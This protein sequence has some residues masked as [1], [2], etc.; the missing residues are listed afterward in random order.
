MVRVVKVHYE[1]QECFQ[2][3][4]MMTL[5][6]STA[7]EQARIADVEPRFLVNSGILEDTALLIIVRSGAMRFI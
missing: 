2:V 1:F 7:K 4:S 6:L 3:M 5:I